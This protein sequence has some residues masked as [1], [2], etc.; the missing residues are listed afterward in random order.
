MISIN[1]QIAATAV[2]EFLARLHPYRYSSNEEFAV[3]RTSFIQGEHYHEEDRAPVPA[4][5]KYAG[6]GDCDP[7]LGVPQL[8]EQSPP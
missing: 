2:N 6:V 5:A 7:L 8:S 1:T 3:I 4:S